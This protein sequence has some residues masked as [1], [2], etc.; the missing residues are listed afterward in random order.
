VLSYVYT[1]PQFIRAIGIFLAVAVA[2]EPFQPT[3]IADHIAD[4]TQ[5]ANKLKTILDTIAASNGMVGTKMPT[6]DDVAYSFVPSGGTYARWAANWW[7][8]SQGGPGNGP[9]AGDPRIWPF[10]AVETYSGASMVDSY[11]PFLPDVIEPGSLPDSF[12]KLLA[13]RIENRK[14]ILYGRL[15]L[16]AARLTINRLGAITGNP[17]PTDPPYEAWSVRSALNILGISLMGSGVF[18]SLLGFLRAVPPYSGG[19]LFPGIGDRFPP[20]PLPKSFR[21][22]FS[23]P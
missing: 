3:V 4:L 13:L 23:P 9:Y 17:I 20:S 18:A 11:W 1:L 6:E 10:G 8:L 19:S 7:D 2:V 21:S 16:P 5:C 14:K 15:G 12:F 22:L